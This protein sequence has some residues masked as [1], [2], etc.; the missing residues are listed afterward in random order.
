VNFEQQQQVNVD[1]QQ[2]VNIDQ[3]QQAHLS[4]PS[5]G[6]TAGGGRAHRRTFSM[7]GSDVL[8]AAVVSMAANAAAGAA[9]TATGGAAVERGEEVLASKRQRTATG[10]YRVGSMSDLDPSAGKKCPLQPFHIACLTV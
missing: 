3:Q 2:Q 5:L 9:S 4:G 7:P 1:Q 10:F 6:H 8:Q